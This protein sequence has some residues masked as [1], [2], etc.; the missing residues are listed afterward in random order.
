VAHIIGTAGNDVIV[1]TV[2]ADRVE[3]GAGNDRINS[4]AG[5]DEIYGGLGN[6]TLTGDAGNDRIFGEDGNDGVYGGGGN[7]Y[8]DGG[9]GDDVIFGDGGNDTIIGGA[10]NDKLYGGAGDDT[11]IWRT[12]DGTDIIDGGTGNDTLVLDLSSSDLTAGLRADLEAYKA[13]SSGQVAAA[14][15]TTGLAVQTTGATFTFASLGLTISVLETTVVKVDGQTVSIDDLLNVAPVAP[16]EVSLTTVEDSPIEGV[17]SASDP[18]GDALTFAI[19][20]G[21]AMGSLTLDAGTG[22]FV[23]TSGADAHGNDA[24]S[25]RITDPSGASVV[26]NVFVGVTAVADAPNISATDTVV[27]VAYRATQKGTNGNDTLRGEQLV[28]SAVVKLDIAASLTDTD[29]SETLSIVIAGVPKS[30]KLS[31]GVKQMDGT[32]LLQ[33]ADLQG[34]EMKAPT[35]S[36][37]VLQITAT[38][39]EGTSVASSS[40]TLE[41]TFEGS[42]STNDRFIASLGNDTYD[43]GAGTN[44]VDYSRIQTAVSVDL[45]NGTASGAGDDRLVSID[46]V[47]GTAKGDKILGSSRDNVIN[48]GDGDDLVVAGAGNDRVNGGAGNDTFID[49]AGDDNYTGGTG[50]DVLDYSTSTAA[51]A[52]TNGRVTG[53][54]NDRYSGVEKIVGSSFADTFKGGKNADT[55]DGGAGNDWFRGFAGSDIFSGGTG[56]D[57]F[58]WLEKDV[59]SGLK[60]QGVDTITDFAAGDIL[61]VSGIL[62]SSLGAKA[63]AK[64]DTATLVKVTDT[65]EGSML[66]VSV[67]SAFYDVVL[68][69]HVHGVTTASLLADGQLIA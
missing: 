66:S 10:G 49:G 18:D 44:M 33:P 62:K 9:I 8:I 12:G 69:Q 1:G 58:T 17:I 32:W 34:L 19:E 27:A 23:Y 65:S 50:Y 45:A 64:S 5:D 21:P 29:G 11:F 52:V 28:A 13:W 37:I 54:G 61:D 36:A 63:Y 4:G 57:T 14:A 26:Q 41:V 59:V 55:F 51:V 38:S 40:A 20:A 7:D 2:E 56:S 6:D 31:A 67:G 46:N 15:S 24:F 43:G 60:S 30:A 39:R 16:S 53:Q 68:L 48:A 42:G 22:A 47:V 35:A 25:V 3:G